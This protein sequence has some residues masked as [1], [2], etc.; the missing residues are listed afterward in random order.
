MDLTI[1]EFAC[2][3]LKSK[4]Q[5]LNYK[6]NHISSILLDNNDELLLYGMNGQFVTMQVNKTTRKV[7]NINPLVN[8]DMLH[9]FSSRADISE[10]MN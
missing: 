6:A 7:V 1:A 4:Q 3:S 8:A 10:L 5:I 2:F 9:L